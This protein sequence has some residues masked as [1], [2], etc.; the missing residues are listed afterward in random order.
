MYNIQNETIVKTAE[1]K[2]KLDNKLLT[3]E[4]ETTIDD[5]IQELKNIIND[6]ETEVYTKEVEQYAKKKKE[7][8]EQISNKIQMRVDCNVSMDDPIFDSEHEIVP[9]NLHPQPPRRTRSLIHLFIP[10]EDYDYNNKEIFFENE[11]PYTSDEGSDSLLSASKCRLPRIDKDIPNSNGISNNN[12]T[13]MHTIIDI[14]NKSSSYEKHLNHSENRNIKKS[15]SF[16]HTV[17]HNVQIRDVNKNYKSIRHNSVDGFFSGNYSHM[18]IGTPRV[19]H[20]RQVQKPLEDFNT[21]KLKS[22]SLDRIDDGLDSMVDIIVTDQKTDNLHLKTQ[23]DSGNTTGTTLSRSTS[24]IF[25]NNRRDFRI[26]KLPTG[27]NQHCDD[28]HKM[29]LPNHRYENRDNEVHYYFPRVQEKCNNSNNS[30]LIT[31]G[32]TNAGMYSGYQVAKNN[33]NSLNNY[34]KIEMSPLKSKSQIGAIGKVTDL[35]SGLY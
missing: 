2:T 9:S 27:N 16:H 29:F 15:E 23:S 1:D 13:G 18:P 7:E 35:P 10:S 3:D 5:V 28:K 20:Q 34:R 17:Q 14:K 11:T 12:R 21:E 22:K 19:N 26:T 30:F 24:N 4:E 33:Q 6:A 32:H 25:L 31:R 8:E